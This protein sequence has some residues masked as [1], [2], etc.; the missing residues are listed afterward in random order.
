[1]SGDGKKKMNPKMRM[2]INVR[3][4]PSGKNPAAAP[5]RTRHPPRPAVGAA[6]A[7]LG[8]LQLAVQCAPFSLDHL[9]NFV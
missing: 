6:T 3:P 5:E 1:M 9:M 8:V 7:H 4:A 2:K